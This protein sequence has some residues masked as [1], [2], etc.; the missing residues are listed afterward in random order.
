MNTDSSRDPLLGNE[1][2][3]EDQRAKD[4]EEHQAA[5]SLPRLLT[6]PELRKPL[7]IVAWIMFAQQVSGQSSRDA[8]EQL[9]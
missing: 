4:P 9:H 1:E 2:D 5:I 8:T 3:T 6:A 7:I